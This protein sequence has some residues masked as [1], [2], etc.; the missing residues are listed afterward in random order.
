MSVQC[1]RVPMLEAKIYSRT[2]VFSDLRN[3][4]SKHSSNCARSSEQQ[5]MLGLGYF[6]LPETI[7]V[8]RDRKSRPKIQV[9]CNTMR[10]FFA[11]SSEKEGLK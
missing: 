6:S 2:D 3:Q 5:D 11:T 8:R 10:N 1:V 7:V 9:A 4:R